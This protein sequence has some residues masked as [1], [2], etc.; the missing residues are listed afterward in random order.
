M[1]RPRHITYNWIVE[2]NLGLCDNYIHTYI[3]AIHTCSLV[4]KLMAVVSCE[5]HL[6]KVKV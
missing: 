6:P 1:T 2:V 4:C 5:F 3:Y